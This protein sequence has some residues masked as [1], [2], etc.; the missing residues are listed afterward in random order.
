VRVK[1]VLTK[2]QLSAALNKLPDWQSN[3]KQT[4][5]K[6]TFAQPDYVAGLVFIARIAVHAEILQHHPDITYTYRSVTVKLT[7]HELHGLTKLDIELATRISKL[8]S[9]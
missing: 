5:L 1:R 2:K 6:A 7:T 4:F 9:P 3:P 8:V